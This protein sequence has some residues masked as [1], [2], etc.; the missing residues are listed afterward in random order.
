MVEYRCYLLGPGDTPYGAVR[1][2]VDAE[3]FLAGTDD[4]ARLRSHTI[5]RQR[6]HSNGFELWRGD[7]LV[8]RHLPHSG[9]ARA[10]NRP[11]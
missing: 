1:I 4:D 2:F 11:A 8:H 3:D 7:M 5:C 10:S 6:N 9:E